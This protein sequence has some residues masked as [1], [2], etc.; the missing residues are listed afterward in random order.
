MSDSDN[1]V[2]EWRTISDES[3]Q[4]L[5]F[6]ATVDVGELDGEQVERL[7]ETGRSLEDAFLAVV[8]QERRRQSD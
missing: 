3:R 7:R 6:E 5:T 4:Y 2:D 1:G 8:E